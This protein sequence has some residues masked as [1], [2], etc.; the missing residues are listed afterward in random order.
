MTPSF[1]YVPGDTIKHDNEQWYVV[2]I[3]IQDGKSI[4]ISKIE[5][6][7]F[8]KYYTTKVI[9]PTTENCEIVDY[10]EVNKDDWYFLSTRDYSITALYF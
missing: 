3:S 1:K 5:T 4:M 8:G 6:G 10:L 2:A 9:I 7:L